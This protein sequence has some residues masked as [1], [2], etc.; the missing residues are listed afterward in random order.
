MNP[1]D[2]APSPGTT[3]HPV[4]S[5]ASSDHPRTPA[6]TATPQGTPIAAIPTSQSVTDYSSSNTTT[7][8]ATSSTAATPQTMAPTP[9]LIPIITPSTANAPPA[10]PY[11]QPIVI[12]PAP[13]AAPIAQ[14]QPPA[15]AQQ[16]TQPAP[17][18]PPPQQPNGLMDALTYLDMVK[19]RFQEHPSVY[20]SF[21]DIM[22]D[23]KSHVIDTPGVIDRVA[24][25]FKGHPELITGFNTF[26]PQGYRI[27]S[28]NDPL[29]P[30]LVW[31]NGDRYTPLELRYAPQPQLPG[32][33]PAG[34]RPIAQPQPMPYSYASPNYP[35]PPPPQQQ[36]Q[37]QQQQ[38]AQ[39]QQ[40]TNNYAPGGYHGQPTMPHATSAAPPARQP[41]H[42]PAPPAPASNPVPA[43]P[44]ST[45]ANGQSRGPVEFNHAISYVNKIK[46]RYAHDADTYK[47]FLE[48]LQTYQKEQK[49]IQEVYAQVRVLFGGAPDLL[50]EFK[51]FLPDHSSQQNQGNRGMMNLSNTATGL[52]GSQAARKSQLGLSG[53]TGANSASA[54]AAA[55][56]AAAKKQSLKRPAPQ[57]QPSPSYT[58][59]PM[60]NAP[61]VPP[62]KKSKLAGTQREKPSMMEEMEFFDKVK[63]HIGNKTNYAEFLKILNLYSQ[64]ILDASTLVEKIKPFLE[65]QSDLMEWFRRFVRIDDAEAITHYTYATERRHIE[66]RDLP[67]SGHSY[68]LLPADFERPIASSIDDIG[69]EVLNDHLVSVPQYDSER[70]FT[71]HRK[72]IYEEALYRVEEERYEF[73]LN[74]EANLHT[75]ALLEP[76]SRKIQAM[77]AEERGKYQLQPGLGGTS[78]TVYQRIIKKIWDSERGKEMI[79]ALHHNPAVAVPVILKRLKQKDEEWRRAQREW[80]KVW[81]ELDTKNFYKSLDHRGIT[82]K[83]SDKKSMTSRQFFNEIENEYKKRTDA[84]P[85][86]FEYYFPDSGV[87]RDIVRLIARLITR[88]AKLSSLADDE[89]LSMRTFYKHTLAQFFLMDDLDIEE[90]YEN[91]SSDSDDDTHSK[92]HSNNTGGGPGSSNSGARDSPAPPTSSSLRKAVLTRRAPKSRKGGDGM[93]LDS[94][95]E[96][97]RGGSAQGGATGSGNDEMMDVTVP[98]VLNGSST[99]TSR[100]NRKDGGMMNGFDSSHKR[101]TYPFFTNE[102]FYSF[103]RLYQLLYSRLLK[104]KELSRELEAHPPRS[105]QFNMVAV[106]LG[107]QARPPEVIPEHRDRFDEL[108]RMVLNMLAAKMDASDYEDKV[109]HMYQTS[110]YPMYTIDKVCLAMAKQIQHITNDS[111]CMELIK[112]YEKYAQMPTLPSRQEIMYRISAEQ[113]CQEE[114]S[115][116]KFEYHPTET[117]L[118]IQLLGKEDLLGDDAA[119]PH[120]RWSIYVDRFAQLQTGETTGG[121]RTEAFLRR[122]LPELADNVQLS[123]EVDAHAGLELKICVNSYRIHFVEGTEDYFRRRRPADRVER[124]ALRERESGVDGTRTKLFKRWLEKRQ[125]DILHARPLE[126]PMGVPTAGSNTAFGTTTNLNAAMEMIR[127][128]QQSAKQSEDQAMMEADDLQAE[129]ASQIAPLPAHQHMQHRHQPSNNSSSSNL[130][131]QQQ[132]GSQEGASQHEEDDDDSVVVSDGEDDNEDNEDGGDGGGMMEMTENRDEEEEE[133]EQAYNNSNNN[134][135]EEGDV[136]ESDQGGDD[137]DLAHDDDMDDIDGDNSRMAE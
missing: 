30:I 86:Q 74:I 18:G 48:V 76:I 9:T 117:R 57:A 84:R 28:T 45:G 66:L 93:D 77:S 55:A 44:L 33:A 58:P 67:K 129:S 111:T 40:S 35:P 42:R 118:T 34:N 130:Q 14:P 31:A 122:N 116:F 20:N 88:Q 114:L 99:S 123:R 62:K 73:D 103:F 70:G 110:A 12:A 125:Q 134:I 54:S 10:R 22:K 136:Y 65:G 119:S 60:T 82:F 38:Q 47:Q 120:E 26:L 17:G 105:E 78:T 98:D 124:D 75:I 50:D 87:H 91:D 29:N 21:L 72:N 53:T 59:M 15:P 23:F 94:D 2:T 64:E 11:Q 36:Q 113:L 52:S 24:T 80:Q 49:P 39:Q 5:S 79:D 41:A 115:M 90:E 97:Q 92:R 56:A 112:L 71:A 51:Q 43:G 27:E 96:T 32:A 1:N 109:R 19:L 63:K 102:P 106:E 25:L 137:Q 128:A 135:D 85:F 4:M 37:Q 127:A 107:L 7:M 83:T 16:P 3:G 101:R 131:Q 8:S 104:M 121:R 69:R 46:T 6:S 81:R 133:Q 126:G 100:R 68:R 95:S 61:S 108:M 13:I 132:Q 89:V